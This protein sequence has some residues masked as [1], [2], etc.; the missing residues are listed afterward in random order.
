MLQKI[1]KSVLLLAFV[2]VVRA[3]AQSG[4]SS[5]IT[6]DPAITIIQPI[7]I[8]K[9]DGKD[10]HFGKFSAYQSDEGTI[11]IS[12]AGVRTYSGD[13][14]LL[15]GSTVGAAKFIVSGLEGSTFDLDLPLS[16]TLTNVTFP[17]DVMEVAE[18][19]TDLLAPFTIGTGGTTTFNVGATLIKGQNDRRGIYSGSFSLTVNYL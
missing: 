16:T 19:T 9:V 10:L 4:Q 18:Y 14:N 2:F 17:T 15:E 5:P 6:I 7:T 1:V 3:E 13:I 12:P 11:T 8:E